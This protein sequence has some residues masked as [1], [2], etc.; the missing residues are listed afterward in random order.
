MAVIQDEFG[1]T[2]GIVT[3]EDIVEQLVGEIVDEYDEEES[4]LVEADG[5]WYVSG[6]MALDDVNDA[7][8]SEFEDEEFDTIGGFVFGFFGRQPREGECIEVDGFKFTVE[9]TDGRRIGRLRVEQIAGSSETLPA[10]QT[11]SSNP[12]F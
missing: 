1:G 4:S 3:T 5:H 6:K 11:R 2:A 12:L 10:E 8:G 7:I 9:Q